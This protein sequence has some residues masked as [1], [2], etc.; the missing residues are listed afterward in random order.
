MEKYTYLSEAVKIKTISEDAK[1]GS[2]EIAG[3][4]SGYGMTIGN[5]LRRALL[6][7]LPGA[8][9]TGFKVKGVP[10]EFTTI[11]GVKE[12]VVEIS[13]NLKKIRFKLHTDQPQI[14]SLKTK[15]EKIVTAADIKL[16][17]EVE[18]VNPEEVIATLTEKNTEL[19]MEIT[20]EKG[21]GYSS[22]ESRK[23]SD[24]LE[25]GIIAI[26]SFFSPVVRVSYNIENMRIG[27]RTDYN[28]LKIEIETDGTVSPSDALHKSANILSDHFK[29]ISG[30]EVGEFEESKEKKS[31]PKTKKKETKKE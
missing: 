20:V 15:G 22:V 16:N 8:A 24:K 30:V 27:D 2:F 19:D 13:L 3:L 18:V 12:D 28:M 6:A 7:S 21:L 31:T 9:I 1:S 26:D 10:H 14:L 5:A 17:S 4:F 29:I 25:I 11:P 23:E